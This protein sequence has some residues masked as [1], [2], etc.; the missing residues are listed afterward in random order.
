MFGLIGIYTE[1]IRLAVALPLFATRFL[2][3]RP[4]L[5]GVG[6]ATATNS[7]HGEKGRARRLFSFVGFNCQ[8]P[9]LAHSGDS[10]RR[11]ECPLSGEAVIG[12]T[13]NQPRFMNTR[14]NAAGRYLGAGAGAA[15]GAAACGLR[16]GAGL[17]AGLGAATAGFGFTDG[18]SMV[19][20]ESGK[21]VQYWF[22]PRSEM[23][24]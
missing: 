20:A 7:R 10:L 3:I 13:A 19:M 21:R 16:A 11:N 8:R 2:C 9:V 6:S 4:F 17:L 24:I 14:P 23:P 18:S 1:H 22:L 5:A 15:P 12:P